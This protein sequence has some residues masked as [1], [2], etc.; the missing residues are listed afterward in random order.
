M[1]L[2]AYIIAFLI[3]WSAHG[4]Q[5][6]SVRIDLAGTE[7]YIIIPKPIETIVSANST[8]YTYAKGSLQEYGAITV[9]EFRQHSVSSRSNAGRLD[10]KVTRQAS[11][12]V[13]ES[14]WTSTDNS[15]L[16][17]T[18]YVTDRK[19]QI[20]FSGFMAEFWRNYIHGCDDWNK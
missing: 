6:I 19:Q 9:T 14:T 15:A 11:I 13:A 1:A 18:V 10:V 17:R 3:P 4:T 5:N 16:I 12:D 2:I 20:L 7:C 8:R